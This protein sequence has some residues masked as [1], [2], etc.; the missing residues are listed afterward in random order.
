MK[1][2]KVVAIIQARMGST[3]LPGKVLLQIKDKPILWHIVNRLKFSKYINS[4]VISTSTSKT[5][6]EIELF[7]K[8]NNINYFKN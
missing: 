2:K 4:V 7:A 8:K 3:R 1:K 5:D 6:D